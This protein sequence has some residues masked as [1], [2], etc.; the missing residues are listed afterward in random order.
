MPDAIL[1]GTGSGFPLRI[2]GNN[3]ALVSTDDNPLTIY[4]P[5]TQ[6]IY[7]ASGTSTGVTGSEIGSIIKFNDSG[8]IV[9]VLSYSN[10]NLVSIGSWV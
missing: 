9:S 2:N 7:L 6:L 4:N 8:S 3:R 10:N 5:K 1:D